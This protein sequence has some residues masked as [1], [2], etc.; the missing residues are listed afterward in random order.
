MHK[1]DPVEY[2]RSSSSQYKWAMELISHID[3]ASDKHILDIGCGDGK[4]TAHLA[5][6]V[7]QGRVMG[8]DLSPEMISFAQAKFSSKDY[9]TLYFQVGDGAC[10][11]FCEEFDLVVSFACLHWIKDIP[12][13]LKGVCRSLRPGGRILFQCGGKGNAAKL[14]DVTEE[15]TR[16]EPFSDYFQGFR[17]PYYFYRPNDYGKW[18]RRAGLSPMRV[19]LVPKDMVHQGQLGLEGFIRSTW[20]PYLE[21]L[22]EN[23]RAQFAREVAGGY[24]DHHP[25]DDQGRS[26]VQM[27]RLEVEAE[28]SG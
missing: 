8:I 13:V 24:I 11:P 27:V 19:E 9:P 18:L 3:I 7:P 5:A 2:E 25:L 15:I 14:L 26:H 12:T 4:I 6:V 28:R 17:F 22:P 1:W 21:R 16:C 23:M 10:L 20:L